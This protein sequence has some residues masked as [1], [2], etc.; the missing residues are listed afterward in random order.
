MILLLIDELSKLLNNRQYGSII[1]DEEINI[2]KES[3][4]VVVYGASDD[5]IEFA[6]A[7][8]EEY[9]CYGSNRFPMSSNGII[10]CN[11]DNPHCPYFKEILRLCKYWLEAKW[12]VEGY[13][14]I[15]TINVP[16]K[17]FDVLEDNKKYCRGIIFKKTDII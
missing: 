5:L 2:A 11:C 9:G 15:Y 7:I 4:L 8:N 16:F 13:S 10:D 14:W 3:N 6:G 1:T 17:T 12:N